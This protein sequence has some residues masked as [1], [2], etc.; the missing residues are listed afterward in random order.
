MMTGDTGYTGSL[1]ADLPSV[2]PT[3]LH[4]KLIL[5]LGGD[6]CMSLILV[7]VSSVLMCVCIQNAQ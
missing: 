4:G 3:D 5:Y 7:N 2:L 1:I 6:M